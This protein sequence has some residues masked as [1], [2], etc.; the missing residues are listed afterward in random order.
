M[1]FPAALR[2]KVGWLSN[3]SQGVIQC[4][5]QEAHLCVEMGIFP[6]LFDH[7][8][9]HSDIATWRMGFLASPVAKAL[10][11]AGILAKKSSAF[12]RAVAISTPRCDLR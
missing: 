4:E 5:D 8:A 12:V 9:E 6:D 10:R 11:T 2:V 7:H 1:R 3:P